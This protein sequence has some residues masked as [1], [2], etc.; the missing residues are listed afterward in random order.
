M[1]IFLI[2]RYPTLVKTCFLY[3]IRDTDNINC[4]RK[5][6]YLKTGLRKRFFTLWYNV[7]IQWGRTLRSRVDVV[8]TCVSEKFMYRVNT[9]FWFFV[10]WVWRSP[11]GDVDRTDS[12]QCVYV[13][14]M[15]IESYTWHLKRWNIPIF[16]NDFVEKL[17]AY[18]VKLLHKYRCR[19]SDTLIRPIDLKMEHLWSNYLFRFGLG[20]IWTWMILLGITCN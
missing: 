11:T 16:D 12:Q 18:C 20:L 9:D 7:E 2:P 13:I 5:H 19:R 14:Y 1:N 10:S 8:K 4:T 17:R 15:Y 6:F 3:Q